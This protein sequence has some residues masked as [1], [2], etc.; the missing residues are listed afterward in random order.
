MNDEAPRCMCNGALS[1]VEP[2]GIEPSSKRPQ[3]VLS[4]CVASS[5]V[6]VQHLGKG[7]PVK[8]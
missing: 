7:T 5:L 4:T 8:A 6:F 2:E 1:N 3:H